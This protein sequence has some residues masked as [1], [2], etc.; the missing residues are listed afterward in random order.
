[1]VCGGSIGGLWWFGVV[2][3]NSVVPLAFDMYT[4]AFIDFV[5]HMLL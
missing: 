4:C 5:I 2:C 1:M 3:G